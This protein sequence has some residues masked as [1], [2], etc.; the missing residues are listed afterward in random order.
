MLVIG[1]VVVVAQSNFVGVFVWLLR[2]AFHGELY[3]HEGVV[4][5]VV[6]GISLNSYCVC[7][8]KGGVALFW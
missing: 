3:A 5:R 8:L 4:I 6:F 2:L 1:F 7:S